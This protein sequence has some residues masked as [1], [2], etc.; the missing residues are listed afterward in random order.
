MVAILAS[1]KYG[2]VI[3]PDYLEFDGLYFP[4]EFF[5]NRTV[6]IHLTAPGNQGFDSAYK[7]CLQSINDLDCEYLDLYLIHWPATSKLKRE[8]PKN[9]EY[10][11]QSWKAM[12]KLQ[13]E[14]GLAICFIIINNTF[15][16]HRPRTTIQVYYRKKPTISSYS[17]KQMDKQH[18][19]L[20]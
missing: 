10:R 11:S 18:I 20:F 7:A 12:E 14:G 13:S 15:I 1:G 5:A 6:F 4:N 17:T 16:L 2:H 19:E 3:I 8:D 9:L